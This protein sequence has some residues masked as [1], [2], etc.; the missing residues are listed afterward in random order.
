MAQ[1][2]ETTS[3]DIGQDSADVAHPG[4]TGIMEAIRSCGKKD[5]LA[6]RVREAAILLA[7]A[8]RELH[9]RRYRRNVLG[10]RH[11]LHPGDGLPLARPKEI[12]NATNTDAEVKELFDKAYEIAER[13]GVE[14]KGRP[15]LWERGAETVPEDVASPTIT[16]ITPQQGDED[17]SRTKSQSNASSGHKDTANLQNNTNKQGVISENGGNAARPLPSWARKPIII[18][19]VDLFLNM[20]N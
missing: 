12:F 13:L 5:G 18:V 9:Y 17:V 11:G 19:P 14:V 4:A 8:E 7:A 15:L 6:S 16:T 3:R 10:S 2:G 1:A 20:L